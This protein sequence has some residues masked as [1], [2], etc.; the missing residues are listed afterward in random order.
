MISSSE[1]FSRQLRLIFLIM[2]TCLAVRVKA[3]FLAINTV[4]SLLRPLFICPGETPIH[5][6]IRKLQLNPVNTAN[7]HILKS[8]PVHA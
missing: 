3:R 4:T 8:Q 6:L 5:F 1:Q 2:K 7:G